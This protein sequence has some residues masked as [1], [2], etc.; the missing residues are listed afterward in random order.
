MKKKT[1]LLSMI[2]ILIRKKIIKVTKGTGD[3]QA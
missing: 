2:S 1:I 3:N